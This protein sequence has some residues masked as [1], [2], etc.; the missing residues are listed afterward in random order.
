MNILQIIQHFHRLDNYYTAWSIK[1]KPLFVSKHT[2]K[3]RDE[4]QIYTRVSFYTSLLNK[5]SKIP[6]IDVRINVIIS[7]RILQVK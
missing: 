4:I 3:N 6:K 2:K 1:I 5:S 7:R